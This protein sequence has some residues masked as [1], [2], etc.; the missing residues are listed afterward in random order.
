MVVGRIGST[1]MRHLGRVSADVERVWF[2][3][4]PLTR[5]NET[6]GWRRPVAGLL[7]AVDLPLSL[8]WPDGQFLAVQRARLIGGGSLGPE[9]Y[10]GIEDEFGAHNYHPLNVV[11]EKGE[12]SWVWDVEGNKYLDFLSAY[13]ALNFGYANPRIVGVLRQQA[14]EVALTSRAFRNKQ[15][16]LLEK[17]L[18][19][20]TGY[21]MMLPM[22]T[23]AEAVETA[24]KAARKWGYDVKGIP[25][26]EAQII[27]C[28]GNFHGRTITIVSFSDDDYQP[29]F[30]P[31]TP[32]FNSVPFGDIS[33]LEKMIEELGAGK[34]A[35]FLVEPIQAEGGILLPPEGY[36]EAAAALCKKH[37]ILFI[38]DEIQTGL[39]RTGK[40]LA[41]EHYGVKPDMITLGKS[42]GGGV[43][44]VSAVLASSEILGVFGWGQHGS[45]FGGNPLA[46]AI[47][48]E[49]LRIIVEEQINEKATRQGEYFMRQLR[50]LKS[51]HI[52]EVRG[53]GLLVGLELNGKARIFCEALAKVGL[54]CKETHDRVI[55]FAPPLIITQDEIDWALKQIRLVFQKLDSFDIAELDGLKEH[56]RK[57]LIDR[58]FNNV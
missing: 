41:S 55:R 27:V 34:I 38:A 24:L 56:Q 25:A 14:G 57:E 12:G 3:P 5:P 20:L 32:G 15:L 18:C 16:P 28:N 2:S 4:G 26:G 6:L 8:I 33:G 30:Y 40:L 35:A 52:K 9:D 39:G 48:R 31:K 47:A 13:S 19:E 53:K 50:A 42:L 44:P 43:F 10:I 29:S 46:C 37:N 23:G 7:K 22:N 36:L 17:E 58:L 11:I 21:G 1:V 51:R 45:T 49:S 54:L